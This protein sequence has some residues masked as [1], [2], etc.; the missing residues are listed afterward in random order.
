[1]PAEA[2][3]PRR[4]WRRVAAD[5]AAEVVIA[6][7][8]LVF[9]GAGGRFA[10]SFG[11][12]AFAVIIGWRLVFRTADRYDD[13]WLG[14]L[15]AQVEDAPAWARC[16]HPAQVLKRRHTA[17]CQRRWGVTP[18]T[19]GWQHLRQAW[20]RDALQASALFAVISHAWWLGL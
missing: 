15:L 19:S 1:M 9:G 18:R 16:P 12:N 20:R 4:S 10:V 6:S 3:R 11:V 14:D 2:Q 8:W 17:W 7:P 13:A 5:G